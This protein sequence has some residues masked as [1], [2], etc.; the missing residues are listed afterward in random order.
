MSEPSQRAMAL[1]AELDDDE[2]SGIHAHTRMH[3]AFA[4]YI[5]VLNTPRPFG[6]WHEDIGDVLWWL[7]PIESAPYCGSPVCLGYTVQVDLTVSSS[8]TVFEPIKRS[9]PFQIGGWPF[10]E[11][12]EHRLFW[13]PLPDANALDVAIRDHIRGG[14]DPFTEESEG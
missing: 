8:Q 10:A 12:D 2:G 4:R 6:E 1:A 7:W 3:R 14:P 9:T 5:D 11:E 13:T